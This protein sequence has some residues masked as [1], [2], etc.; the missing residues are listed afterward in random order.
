MRLEAFS[1]RTSG[2]AGDARERHSKHRR[3]HRRRLRETLPL[4]PRAFSTDPEAYSPGQ[5]F[6]NI[7]SLAL[8]SPSTFSSVIMHA[9]NVEL[10]KG[11]YHMVSF[12]K[13]FLCAQGNGRNFTFA[14]P[15][16]VASTGFTVNATLDGPVDP[17]QFQLYCAPGAGQ[18][19]N[20]S[21]ALP[22]VASALGTTSESTHKCSICTCNLI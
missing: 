22:G 11:G 8:V 19:Q 9:C 18:S 2:S 16:Y 12:V 6:Y 3:S 10:G 14:Q 13:A 17:G 15:G 5:V 4:L 1:V 21:A 20:R 7:Y